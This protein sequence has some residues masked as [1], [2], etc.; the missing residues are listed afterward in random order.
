MSDK[1]P[2]DP[3]QVGI[4]INN[5][6]KNYQVHATDALN[7]K[8]DIKPILKFKSSDAKEDIY[9][10]KLKS[11]MKAIMYIMD[12]DKDCRDINK[13]VQAWEIS[14]IALHVGVPPEVIGALIKQETHFSTD[15]ADMNKGNGVG[16]MQITPITIQ[17][18]YERPQAFEPKI[19]Q[20]IGSKNKPY[21]TFAQALQAKLKNSSID[22][23]EFGNKFFEFYKDNTE[24]FDKYKGIY[25]NAPKNIQDKYT[26]ILSNYNRN[27]YLGCWIY[28]SKLRGH[29]EKQA[30]I[31][32]NGSSI[33]YKY[34]KE[35][36]DTIKKV[37]T[38]V[39]EVKILKQ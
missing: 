10:K 25:K 17:D 12:I 15:S 31:N 9:S 32:Y 7:V 18:M 29:S 27:V 5:S 22:L 11:A 34:E 37:R 16:P 28:K 26:E 1:I 39:P 13:E 20:L 24:Y 38:N 21:K 8:K 6:I 23:G 33:K 2:F 3:K 19:G 36:S 30:L 35:V 14:R 4:F